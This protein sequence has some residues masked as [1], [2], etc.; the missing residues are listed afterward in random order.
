MITIRDSNGEMKIEMSGIAEKSFLE[1]IQIGK[2]ISLR[3]KRE[4][5]LV[6]ALSRDL[7]VTPCTGIKT[8]IW[9]TDRIIYEPLK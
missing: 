8:F 3:V 1:S 7:K 2:P 5:V 4:G 6:W 9:T